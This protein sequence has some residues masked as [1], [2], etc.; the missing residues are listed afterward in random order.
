MVSSYMEIRALGRAQKPSNY[1]FN[2]PDS[3]SDLISRIG[4]LQSSNDSVILKKVIARRVQLYVEGSLPY[5]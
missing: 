4:P 2:L 5:S 1:E 3:I